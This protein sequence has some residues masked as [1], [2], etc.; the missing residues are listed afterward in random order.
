M[1]LNQRTLSTNAS[2]EIESASSTAEAN[3]LRIKDLEEQVRDLMVFLDAREFSGGGEGASGSQSSQSIQG[4]DVLGIAPPREADGVD[5]APSRSDVHAR[6]Q[7]KLQQR[8]Q[9][10]GG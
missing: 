7:K 9:K 4:G 3:Y 8:K 1:T 6:L 2:K 10:R 5:D